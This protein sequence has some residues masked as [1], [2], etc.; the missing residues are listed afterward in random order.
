MRYPTTPSVD[1]ILNNKLYIGNLA[2]ATS[3]ETLERL[4]ITHILSVCPEFASTGPNHM[5]ISV[6]DSEYDD[7]LIFLPRACQFIQQALEGE[8]RVLVHCVVGVSRSAT[9]AAAYL[10]QS[11]QWT[12][13]TALDFIRKRR[14][15]VQPNYGFLKQL[16]AFADCHYSP[17]IS[18]PAYISW[19]RHS[20]QKVTAFL[21]QMIDTVVIIPNQL[22]LSSEFPD[23]AVQAE[24]LMV[25]LE[26]SHLVSISPSRVPKLPSTVKHL[27][28]N[29]LQKD[30]L[31]TAIPGICNFIQEAI[32]SKSQ[33]LVYS[34]VEC[35]AAIVV[36]CYL[37]W[38]RSMSAN[39]A[40]H[41]LEKALPL[42]HRTANF[43]SHLELYGACGFAPTS[44]HPLVK[45][46]VGKCSTSSPLKGTYSQEM[47]AAITATAMA[48][49]LSDTTVDI[50]AFGEAL[51]KIQHSGR[52][53]DLAAAVQTVQ[54]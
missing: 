42:F 11:R 22:F 47:A 12:S 4:G 21:N 8:G 18:N 24:S 26:L 7:L 53:T 32:V 28:A 3:T 44:D 2:A 27:H 30:D 5:N 46:W 16:D 15:C 49:V 52:K 54:C 29:A 25:E 34:D 35:K 43:T 19:K 39:E 14:P 33:V 23:D 31:L 40:S 41:V 38:T 45:D 6:D 20:S 51:K 13:A 36:C 10:M 37:M 50:G 48:S 17:S 9:V 1:E